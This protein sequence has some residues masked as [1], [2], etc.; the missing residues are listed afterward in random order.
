MASSVGVVDCRGTQGTRTYDTD[1]TDGSKQRPLDQ[2][3]ELVY[4]IT[5]MKCTCRWRPNGLFLS[6]QAGSLVLV[7]T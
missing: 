1:F 4:L 5:T 3:P 7:E 2:V 6:F